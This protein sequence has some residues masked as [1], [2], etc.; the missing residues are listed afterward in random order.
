MST[1]NVIDSADRISGLDLNAANLSAASAGGD[2]IPAGPDIYLRVKCGTT[3]C[4]ATVI[5]AG[6]NAGR[7]G[8]SAPTL[9]A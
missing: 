8:A 3:A 6:A 7:D 1:L 9:N 4:I 2:K 5:A